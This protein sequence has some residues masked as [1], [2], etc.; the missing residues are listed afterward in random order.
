MKRRCKSFRDIGARSYGLASKYCCGPHVCGL[1]CSKSDWTESCVSDTILLSGDMGTVSGAC[2]IGLFMWNLLL[3]DFFFSLLVAVVP[4]YLVLRLAGFGKVASISFAP[5]TSFLAM[6]A[7]VFILRSLGI[8]ATWQTAILCILTETALTCAAVALLRRK[9]SLSFDADFRLIAIA[10]GVSAVAVFFYY[11]LPLDTAASFYQENDNIAHLSTVREF[12]DTGVFCHDSIASYPALWRTFTAI[13]ASFGSGEVT[14]A[15]NAVNLLFITYVY[16]SAMTA[17]IQTVF[18][19]RKR[20]QLLASC[21]VSAFAVFPWGLLLFGPLYPNVVGNALLPLAMVAFIM[22][23]RSE[24]HKEILGWSVLFVLGCLLLF[25]AHPNA[26]FTGVVI[27]TPLCVRTIWDRTSSCGA[28][29]R[30]R[31]L[32]CCFFILFVIVVWTILYK[33][34]VMKGVVSF[35]W[36]SYTSVSQALI[37][38]VSLALTK[39]SAPQLI[40]GALVLIGLFVSLK[41]EDDYWIAASYALLAI[42]YVA[43]VALGGRIQHYLAGFWYSD[44]FRVASSFVYVLII[45]ASLGLDYLLTKAAE[46][47]EGLHAGTLKEHSTAR[48]LAGM[49]CLLLIIFYPNFSIPKN[50][51]VTTGFGMVREMLTSGNLLAENQNGLDKEEMQFIQEVHSI[52]GNERVLNYPYDGSAYAF[53]TDDLNVVNRGWYEN[54]DQDIA[55]LGRDADE[56]S[57]NAEVRAAFHSSGIKY[58]MLLDYDKENGGLYMA[59][60]YSQPSWSGLEKLNDETPGYRIV[61][62]KGD[63]RLYEVE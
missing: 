55:L 15:A 31:K 53:A 30:K 47:R 61:L 41:S 3:Y 36:P 49:G 62:E 35:D 28:A 18:S 14:V 27:L 51:Y 38:I 10:C 58:V 48:S 20:L 42:I 21:L 11:V 19:G 60:G 16:P 7:S 57:S 1:R 40:L 17:F 44:S 29:V 26:L 25:Y 24:G 39:A 12:L 45:L 46:L 59:A 2:R 56:A 37:N 5:L 34:P 43:D 32:L 8:W 23:I 52:V 9:T 50:M 54:G 4:G 13:V 63:M 6:T 22:A 33:L